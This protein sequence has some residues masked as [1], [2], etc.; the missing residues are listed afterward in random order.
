MSG[1]TPSGTVKEY[2]TV[3]YCCLS[4]EKS[5]VKKSLIVESCCFHTENSVVKDFLTTAENV[6]GC[7][8]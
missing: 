5:T 8:L 4:P 2:L 1:V 7:K 6:M 3:G